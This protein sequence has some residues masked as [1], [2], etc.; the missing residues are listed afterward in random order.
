[1][2]LK[3]DSTVGAFIMNKILQESPPSNQPEFGAFN[4]RDKQSIKEE[5]SGSIEMS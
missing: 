2:L 5:K 4:S 3:K 1:M